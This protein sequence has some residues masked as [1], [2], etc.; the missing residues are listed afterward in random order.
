MPL[1]PLSPDFQAKTKLKEHYG[2]LK[3]QLKRWLMVD[4]TIYKNRR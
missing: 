2:I 3:E 4:D 1:S